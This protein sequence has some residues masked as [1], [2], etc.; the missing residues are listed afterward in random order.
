MTRR[1][2]SNVLWTPSRSSHSVIRLPPP[3]TST[4]GRRRA[5]AATSSSTWLWSAIVVPPSLTTRISHRPPHVAAA[6]PTGC[7]LVLDAARLDVAAR[8]VVYSQFSMT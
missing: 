3:W 7:A 8:H 6:S 5:T 4:T 1:P 2:P